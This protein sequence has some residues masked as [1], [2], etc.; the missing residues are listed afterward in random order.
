MVGDGIFDLNAEHQTFTETFE[1][2]E[3]SKSRKIRKSPTLR[4]FFKNNLEFE[5]FLRRN[6][7]KI[8]REMKN[9]DGFGEQALLWNVKRTAT[10]VAKNDC[11]LLVIEKKDFV[12]IL[13]QYKDAY[14]R[15]DDL[16]DEVFPQIKKLIM[17]SKII[18][19]ITH[20]FKNIKLTKGAVLTKENVENANGKIFIVEEG[21]FLVEKKCSENE[22]KKIAGENFFKIQ[23]NTSNFAITLKLCIQGRKSIIGEEMLFREKGMYSY[24]VTC[25]SQEASVLEISKNDIKMHCPRFFIEGLLKV[26]EGKKENRLE[27]MR[28]QLMGICDKF[29]DEVVNK[30]KREAQRNFLEIRKK[31]EKARESEEKE[32]KVLEKL[33]RNEEK[34]LLKKEILGK[35]ASEKTL[36]INQTNDKID[37]SALSSRRKPETPNLS[38]ELIQ[39]L[40]IRKKP[41]VKLKDE[42]RKI[43]KNFLISQTSAYLK[44]REDLV[45][46]Q[47]LASIHNFSDL[48]DS[49]KNSLEQFNDLFGSEIPKKQKKIND[50]K[51]HS[52]YNE[53]KEKTCRGNSSGK[54]KSWLIDRFLLKT[55]E[56]VTLMRK[57]LWSNSIEGI[58]SKSQ[59]ISRDGEE[60]EPYGIGIRALKAKENY[61]R[62]IS[63]EH[64]ALFRKT[65]GTETEEIK[66][67]IENVSGESLKLKLRENKIKC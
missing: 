66:G 23:Q 46:Q 15:K 50:L 10:V 53:K 8:V 63:S 37:E 14:F 30:N 67:R 48:K 18:Q 56:N 36:T 2:K 34:K 58:S 65:W 59:Y 13:D 21:E 24:T 5:E 33:N 54:S 16:I 60:N 29:K 12:P 9:G 35:I 22:L 39:N 61:L 38:H 19:S 62:K 64:K 40:I 26:H 20:S 11:D 3:V 52:I 45:S 49:R 51:I 57:D 6:F 32:S 28:E 4:N 7:G 41:E 31:E 44:N 43:T 25:I 27:L 42:I 55:K 47:K 1:A 17:S